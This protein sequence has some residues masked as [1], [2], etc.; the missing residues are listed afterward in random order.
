MPLSLNMP[1]MWLATQLGASIPSPSQGVWQI[2]PFPLR[3]Y[4]L[5]LLAG[6][7]LAVGW[8]ER[9]YRAAGGERDT[10]VDLA[11]LSVPLG[12]VGA[13]LYHVLTSP[14]AY[15]GPEGSL[16]NIPRI[17]EGG[18]GIWGGIS[19]GAATCAVLLWRRGLRV[20]PFAD[21][22]APGVLAAQ[23]I[24][25]FGNWFNQELFGGPTTLPWGLEID[26]AHL[27]AGYPSG[28]LFHPT[29]LYEALWNAAGVL[30]LLW[31]ARRLKA[32][33]GATGGRIMWAY[34]MVYTAGRAWIEMLRVDDAQ[35]IAGLRLNVWTSLLVFLAGL[36]GYIW[37]SRRGPSDAVRRKHDAA[38]DLE[39]ATDA[40]TEL[41]GSG[42]GKEGKSVVE[43]ASSEP[44]TSSAIS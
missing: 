6:I 13:R 44:E 23:A 32:R 19:A 35:L 21:A 43:A 42:E 28:T 12:I 34:M 38:A 31:L 14:D 18:I 11:L 20:A 40:A 39:V 9:R 7:F 17:W 4:A 8:G 16:A 26:D 30:V 41:G 10:V 37:T 1:G 27:P 25:R 22:L 24:G 29:F 33:D 2:G 5:C 36:L 15:F 3:A